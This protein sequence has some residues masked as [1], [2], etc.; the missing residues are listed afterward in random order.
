[1]A[2]IASTARRCGFPTRRSPTCSSSGRNRPRMTT[3]IRGF[4]LEKGMKG[5]PRRRIGG[6][7]SL[8]CLDHRR[9]VLDNVEVPEDALLP[10]VSGLPVRSAVSTARATASPGAMGAAEDC[11][12]RARQYGSTASSSAVRWR[13]RNCVQKKLAD[14]QTEITL[15]LQGRCASAACSTKADG[16][17]ND[18]DHQAQQLRQGAR[19]RPHGARHARRQRHPDRIPRDAPRRRTSRRSTPTRARTTCTR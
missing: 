10:N 5:L 9:V 4:V 1:M 17:R 6:K 15:G 3:S 19:H 2:A 14:M 16:A 13:R 8:A 7:L 18:L 11:W 12:H